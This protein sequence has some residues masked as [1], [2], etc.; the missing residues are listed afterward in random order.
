MDICAEVLACVERRKVSWLML[1]QLAETDAKLGHLLLLA[2]DQHT[3]LLPLAFYSLLSCFSDGTTV[4]EAAF[5]H[6]A[7]DMYLKLVQLFVDGE[8]KI[9]LPQA[10]R[11]VKLPSHSELQ[12]SPVQLITKARSFLLQL[13][14]QCP[15]QCFSNMTEVTNPDMSSRAHFIT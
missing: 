2:P 13:I 4:R 5:L 7:V 10:S 14:P 12:D 3:R 15:R 9:V 6:V 1:F 8:T 11:S